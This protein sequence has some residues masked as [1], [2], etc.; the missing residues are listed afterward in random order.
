ME[1][2]IAIIGYGSMGKMLL[3]KIISSKLI[4]EVNIYVSNRNFEKIEVLKEKYTVNICRTNAEAAEN[5]DVIFVCVRP[6]DIKTVLEEIETVMNSDKHIISLNGSIKF[7]QLEK[8]CT[9]NK[10]SKV[11]PSVT[12]EVNESQTLVCYNSKVNEKDKSELNK[13]LE[14]FGNV[15]ELPEEEMGMGAE[16]VSCMP[17]FTAALFNEIKKGAQ[18][19]TKIKENKIVTMLANTMIGTGRLII[20][21]KMTFEEVIKRVATKG[22]ITEEGTKVIEQEFPK[23]V[24][25][26]FDKTLEKR[27]IM[28]ENAVKAFGK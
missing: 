15:I 20:E 13:I 10:I 14:S 8:I 12:A 25:E 16:L 22:G 19:H 3:E 23:V 18:K 5:A 7:D 2:G 27:K 11:I 4:P 28:T 9:G 26:M 6:A 24:T 17:G 1:T 21:N